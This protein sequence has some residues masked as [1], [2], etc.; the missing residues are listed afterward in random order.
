MALPDSSERFVF[1][2][3]RQAAPQ[4]A[5]Y[6]RE[7]I[8]SLEL[9]PGLAMSRADLQKQFGLSQTP[10]RDALL[11]LEEEGLVTVFPQYATLVSRVNLRQA[12][13]AH[14]M[15]RA[16]EADV[17]RLLAENRTDALVTDLRKANALVRVEA[18]AADHAA[19]LVA[20]RA[21]HQTMFQHADMMI[22]WS[23]VRNS[24]GHLDRLRRLNLKNVGVDRIVRQHEDVIDAIDKGDPDRAEAALRTHLANTL[25]LLERVVGEFPEYIER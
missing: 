14:F 8:L 22:V 7:K 24:S 10:V 5:D 4:I 6:L 18:E 12:R 15:R 21:F 16:I 1:D 2:R 9:A 23:L 13:Q 19:F 17:V 20:D 3:T 25:A 11:K